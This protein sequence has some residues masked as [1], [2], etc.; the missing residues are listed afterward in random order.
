MEINNINNLV[1]KPI[2]DSKTFDSH[3]E[4]TSPK[5]KGTDDKLLNAV[6][7]MCG[8]AGE[9]SDMFKKYKYQ[10]HALDIDDVKEELGDVLWYITLAAHAVDSSLGEI[11]QINIDKLNKRYPNGF[12]AERSV[13]RDKYEKSED[14]DNKDSNTDILNNLMGSIFGMAVLSELFKKST[15]DKENDEEE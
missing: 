13:N 11:M 2:M 6:L 3:V 10:G 7:G 15:K 14:S 4:R 1:Y 5:H 8:E 12:E 9:V